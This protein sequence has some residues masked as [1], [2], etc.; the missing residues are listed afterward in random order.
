MK[1]YTVITYEIDVE[2]FG[3]EGEEYTTRRTYSVS[4]DSQKAKEDFITAAIA[5][6]GDI[7]EV[8][9]IPMWQHKGY[10]ILALVYAICTMAWRRE[11]GSNTFYNLMEKGMFDAGKSKIAAWFDH[12]GYYYDNRKE[13]PIYIMSLDYDDAPVGVS[14]ALTGAWKCRLMYLFWD[15]QWVHIEKIFGCDF[16]R[17]VAN[18]KE[19][20]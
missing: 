11:S 14:K 9:E 3:A 13:T 7:I 6:G 12:M 8:K 2:A 1:T 20:M 5:D 16:D 15:H 18:G 10:Q 19:V 17:L 4:F